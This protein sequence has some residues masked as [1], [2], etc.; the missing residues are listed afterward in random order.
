MNLNT[1]YKTFSVLTGTYQTI[2]PENSFYGSS[3]C[4]PENALENIA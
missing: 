2:L 1:I 4:N 3:D